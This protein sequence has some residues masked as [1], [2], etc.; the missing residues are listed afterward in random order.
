MN[1]ATLQATV[2]WKA[3]GPDTGEVEG[4]ASVFGNVDETGDVVMP[5]AFRKTIEDWRRASQPMPLIA[6]HDLSTDGV[7]G[8]ITHLS[9]EPRGLRFKARFSRSE[10]AQ[11][12]RQD[13]ID[14]HLRGTSF[15]YEAK[16]ARPGKGQTIGGKAVGRFLDAL[17]LFEITV[18]PFPMNALAGV[19]GAKAV[20]QAAWDG[21][22]SRFTIE[23]W[24]KSTLIDTGTG[25]TDTFDRYKLP[26]LEPNGDV[27]AN[28]VHAA[29]AV[30]AGGRG[31]VTASPE[32]KR[33]AA[34]KAA[35]LYGQMGEDMPDSL[36]TM[37]GMGS[38]SYA[39]WLASMEHATAIV[40]PYARKA[41]IDELVRNYPTDSDLLEA[42]VED[43]PG[44]ASDAA[45][46]PDGAVDT[47]AQSDAG[48]YA[49]S[50]LQ[51]QSDGTPAEPESTPALDIIRGAEVDRALA[52]IN[53]LEQ[54][55]EEADTHV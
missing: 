42:A 13:I 15:T 24:R 40:D 35:G 46:T 20:T 47:S 55:I 31:G 5:G 2:E 48:A 44:T 8:S 18:T 1:R 22:P 23:Q 12:I 19:T 39:S 25:G 49:V 37:A 27:N 53:A 54:A 11:R 4:F 52:D 34:R 50:F 41:A 51:G 29:A 43:A 14:G 33:A 36:R 21:S 32:Q 28:A 3:T 17:R 9:E 7:I 38:A 10:K 16:S 45:D 6:D 30:L 26:V